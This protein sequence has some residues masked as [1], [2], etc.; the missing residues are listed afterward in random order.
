[1][2]GYMQQAK[3]QLLITGANGFIGSR[4]SECAC[5][6]W[7]IRR[8]V[9]QPLVG[10][11][12]VVG[13]LGAD[14][15][16]FAALHGCEAV[17]HLA[18]RVHIMS[19]HAKSP[20]EEFRKINTIGTL[21][22]AQQAVESGVKRFIYLSSI[23]VN[24]EFTLL[25]SPFTPDDIFIPTDPYALSKYEAEQGLLDL[26]R[27]S[28]M[29]V[30]IIRPPLVYGPDVKANFLSMMKWLYKSI[31]LPFGSIHNKR[32]LVALDN[33]IDLIITCIKHP[34]AANE[35]FLV[36]DG[37]DLS[38]SE[39]L[40]QVSFALGK[41]SRL[42]PVN[43]K[44]LEFCLGLIGKKDLSQRLCGSLQVDISK[45]KNLLNWTPP[46]DISNSL[47]ETVE[48]FLKREII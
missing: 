6:N 38:T 23:K 43:Q 31:P 22:L 35:V 46:V 42:L 44:V 25:G 34:A 3:S 10:N 8:Q 30:V 26:A 41:R 13:D 33:L 4:L 36:S 24:G 11:E 1:M 47:K 39:L 19:D 12:I 32:S 45:T 14:T 15:D 27:K 48:H 2:A 28:Q 40:K 16:W 9:R 7:N 29:E 17:V 21:N 20:I 18:G 37:E 5:K